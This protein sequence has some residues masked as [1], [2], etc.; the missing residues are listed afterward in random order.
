MPTERCARLMAVSMANKLDEVWISEYPS[1]LNVYLNQYFPNLFR[2]YVCLVVHVVVF[3]N[4]SLW[5]SLKFTVFNRNLSLLIW[6]KM[7]LDIPVSMRRKMS[8]L[9]HL[10]SVSSSLDFF[11]FPILL[12]PFPSPFPISSFL[13]PP[14]PFL[15]FPSPSFFFSYLPLHL[16]SNP[17]SAFPLSI[18]PS[19]VPPLPFPLPCPLSSLP[20][21]SPCAW[22]INLNLV[23]N[24]IVIFS[25]GFPRNIWWKLWQNCTWILEQKPL[26]SLRK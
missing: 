7:K 12:S 25:L 15:Y 8:I 20:L 18:F 16:F 9:Q 22:L 2:W 14:S 4:C 24:V 6:L 5:S 23:L 21:S 13:L 3:Q 11:P 1:L 26:H 19:P 10:C 17:L